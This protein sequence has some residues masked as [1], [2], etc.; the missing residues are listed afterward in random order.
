MHTVKIYVDYIFY[1][2][3]ALAYVA[4]SHFSEAWLTQIGNIAEKAGNIE[5]Y[6]DNDY[7]NWE[8]QQPAILLHELFH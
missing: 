5:V 1:Y 3:N 6:S 4:I 8:I 7:V 2:N